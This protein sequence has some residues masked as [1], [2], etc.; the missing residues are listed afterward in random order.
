MGL[1]FSKEHIA[2]GTDDRYGGGCFKNNLLFTE[3]SELY[4]Y[5]FLSFRLKSKK[6]CG[7]TKKKSKNMGNY[8]KEILHILQC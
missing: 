3:V 2:S 8:S 6:K 7:L 1:S 4:I 5:F